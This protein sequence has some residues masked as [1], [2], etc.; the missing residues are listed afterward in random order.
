MTCRLYIDEVG[1]D[2][3]SSPTERYLSLTGIITK[4]RSH[5]NT[6]RPAIEQLK[7]DLFGHDPPKNI[8]ILHRREI[9]R[10][11]PPFDCLRDKGQ[12]ARWEVG[13][14]KLIES[15]PYI[16]ITVMIDKHEHAQKYAVWQFNPY[17]YCMRALVERYVLELNSKGLTGD[18]VAEPRFK[19]QDKKLKKSFSYIYDHGTENIPAWRVQQCITSREIKFEAK[20]ANVCGL[21]LVEMIAH[22][23][24]Q[25]LKAEYTGF[26]MAARFGTRVVEILLRSRYRRNPRNQMI[27]GWGRKRL[28]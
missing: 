10:K 27:D 11:E 1:N 7:A 4:K 20:R 12:N 8:V 6:I 21:Q 23:S 22:P 24:H 17:H 2:D 28:P 9:V 5:D 19:K 18:V 16:A 26:P 3:T 15:L 25:S 13:L 14:L